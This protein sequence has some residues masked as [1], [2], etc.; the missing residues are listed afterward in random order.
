MPNITFTFSGWV[1][2]EINTAHDIYGKDVD[3]SK[4]PA[5][6]LAE[7]LEEG[8]LFISLGDHIYSS[9]KNEVEL[10]DFAAA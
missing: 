2:D 9:M 7:K 6:E 1:R 5:A 10:S 8:D 4:M 3:V